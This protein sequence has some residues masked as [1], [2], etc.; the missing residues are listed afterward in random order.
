MGDH[1]ALLQSESMHRLY[2]PQPLITAEVVP[3]T[4]APVH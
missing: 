2:H 4:I 1:Q 3:F